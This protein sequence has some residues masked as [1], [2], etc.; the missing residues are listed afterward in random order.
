MKGTGGCQPEPW[1]CRERGSLCL[2]P[3][4]GTTLDEQVS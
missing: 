1:L 4:R 3:R 2:R